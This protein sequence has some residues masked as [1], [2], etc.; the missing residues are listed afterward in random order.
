[1]EIVIGN[2]PPLKNPSSPGMA[3]GG[4]IVEGKLLNIRP[5]RKGRQQPPPAGQRERRRKA[6]VRDNPGGRVVTLFIP[7]GY[8][9]PKDLDSGNYRLFLKFMPRRK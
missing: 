4:G 9:I 6:T 3:P 1:M 5:P 2:I 7:E 8:K